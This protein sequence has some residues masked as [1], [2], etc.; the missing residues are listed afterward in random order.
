MYVCTWGLAVNRPFRA[1]PRFCFHSS[2]SLV[3]TT[4]ISILPVVQTTLDLRLTHSLYI[5]ISL[6]LFYSV[7]LY[8]HVYICTLCPPSLCTTRLRFVNSNAHYPLKRNAV[9]DM[10]VFFFFLL[11]FFH[12]IPFFFFFFDCLYRRISFF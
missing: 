7:I 4:V 10:I 9:Q 11:F 5:S 6:P 3:S 12:F 1:F 2:S 8:C